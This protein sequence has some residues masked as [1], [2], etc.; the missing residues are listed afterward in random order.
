VIYTGAIK[1]PEQLQKSVRGTFY[2]STDFATI[3]PT[4]MEMRRLAVNEN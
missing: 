3:A 2:K 1:V 4:I